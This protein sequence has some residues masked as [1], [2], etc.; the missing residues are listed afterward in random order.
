MRAGHDIDVYHI[1]VEHENTIR[2]LV[3]N[4]AEG[5]EHSFAM[6]TGPAVP[7]SL[8][9]GVQTDGILK[10]AEHN[11]NLCFW[12][13][14]GP[15]FVYHNSFP[16]P[17]FICIPFTILRYQNLI[18]RDANGRQVPS[19]MQW[20]TEGPHIVLNVLEAPVFPILIGMINYL[21]FPLSFV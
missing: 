21:F 3:E 15:V 4:I 9:L 6:A 14:D 7:F 5:I 18:V 1:S 2:E 11:S 16:F 13:K 20:E 17:S 8:R 12:G 10:I 19:N